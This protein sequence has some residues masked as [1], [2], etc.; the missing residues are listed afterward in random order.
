M[1]GALR[2]E[3][4]YHPLYGDRNLE[5]I[6]PR[7]YLSDLHRALD[8]TTQGFGREGIQAYAKVVEGLAGVEAAGPDST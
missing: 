7:V 1:I 4:G 3:S 5:V 8:I 6:R 2:L